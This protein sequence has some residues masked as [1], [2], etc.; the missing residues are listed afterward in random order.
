MAR[1]PPTATRRRTARS[2]G[3]AGAVRPEVRGAPGVGEH[4]PVL[5][6]AR[7]AYDFVI[8]L[9]VASGHE[10]SDL[11]AEDA[12]WLGTAA[13]SLPADLRAELAACYETPSLGAIHALPSLI[14]DDPTMRAGADV[15]AAIAS[16]DPV[17]LARRFL[18]DFLPGDAA[19]RLTDGAL[20]DD[21]EAVAT[22]RA[23]L[24]DYGKGEAVE[25]VLRPEPAVERLRSVV[26]AWLPLFQA[27]EPRVA[28]ML[29]RDLQARSNDRRDLE[30]PALIER[31]TGGLRWLP[32]PR[33]R[34]VIMAPSYFAR[35][36][37]YVYQGGDWRLFAYP[38]ADSALG[39]EDRAMPPAAVVR[40]YRALGDATRMRI[41]RLLADR[42][43]YLTELA[44]QLGLSKPTVKHH[45][46]L[47]R[48]A[49]LATVSEEGSLT[50][51]SLRRE[52]LDEAGSEL[53]RYLG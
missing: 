46:A 43:W 2:A 37:N 39:A 12:D 11:L 44:T 17:Q 6:E 41:L 24:E 27:V 45:L 18:A 16:V 52:R 29:D 34:R 19:E 9:G 20:S 49:G 3:P 40:L 36:F 23:Q 8:S 22:V 53:H 25:F 7:T 30:P 31:T 4:P 47:L 10:E 15:V 1:K 33:V 51:Y 21:A 35:P 42:D 5:F 13:A 50:W 26:E 32:E 28:L 38:L 48:A 14:V